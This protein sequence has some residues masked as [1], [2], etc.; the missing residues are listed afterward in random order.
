MRGQ[1][2]H[3][4]KGLVVEAEVYSG[5]DDI[6]C[7]GPISKVL[8][9]LLVHTG[10]P[11]TAMLECRSDS[12]KKKRRPALSSRLPLSPG[13]ENLDILCT[14]GVFG[15]GVTLGRTLILLP[16]TLTPSEAF[17][18]QRTH[19]TPLDQTGYVNSLQVVLSHVGLNL[20]SAKDSTR[21]QAATWYMKGKRWQH[22]MLGWST[23]HEIDFQMAGHIYDR[24][25]RGT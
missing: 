22:K 19:S 23:E 3:R 16:H 2:N 12:K 5:L 25:W 14:S 7:P 9:Y 24:S 4:Q 6:G 13:Y 10:E 20:A 17:V 18:P 11:W 15:T 1:D 21:L 8:I